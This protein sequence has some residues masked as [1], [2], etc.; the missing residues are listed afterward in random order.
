MN[1]V[2]RLRAAKKILLPSEP[3][4]LDSPSR[5]GLN[6]RSP[7]R[8]PAKAAPVAIGSALNPVRPYGSLSPLQQ[9]RIGPL[10][11][12]WTTRNGDQPACGNCCSEA[13]LPS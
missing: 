10:S 12:G 11:G 2:K 5:D 13:R 6:G 4:D 1:F 3:V 9:P 7:V 8:N